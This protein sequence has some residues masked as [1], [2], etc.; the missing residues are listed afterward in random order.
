MSH[1]GEKVVFIPYGCPEDQLLVEVTQDKK[2]FCKAKIIEI[3]RPSSQRVEAPCPYFGSCGGCDW[4]HISYP[5]QLLWKH[6]NLTETLARIGKISLQP[7][8]VAPS[9]RPYHY[10]NRIQVH[11]NNKGVYFLKKESHEPVFIE[12]CKIAN[13]VI[14]DFL[15]TAELPRN[16]KWELAMIDDQVEIFPVDPK[17][18]SQLGFRQVNNE[19]NQKIIDLTLQVILENKIR[20]F[21]DLYCGAGNWSLALTQRDQQLQTVGIDNNKISIAKAQSLANQRTKFILGDVSTVFPLDSIPP[22]LIIID[23]PR[24]GCSQKFISKITQT[25]T[26]WLIYISCHPATLARDLQSFVSANWKVMDIVPVDMFPQTAHLESWCLLR[27]DR[28]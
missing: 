28:V 18:R 13:P 20:Y 10:R 17:G 22:E 15:T 27:S 7:Q 1:I 3:I 23:P 24:A 8:A 5:S 2:T 9:P 25:H 19:Q 12:N 21:Y 4:Q 11:K 14:N 6:K 16:G 26:Q